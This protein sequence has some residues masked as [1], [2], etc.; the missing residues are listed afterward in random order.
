MA[1][2]VTGPACLQCGSTEGLH[3]CPGPTDPYPGP[4]SRL[5]LEVNTE[6]E[7]GMFRD[8]PGRTTVRVVR[9]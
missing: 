5:V 1:D 2:D 7:R 4:A 9:P 6:V 8:Y 3:V